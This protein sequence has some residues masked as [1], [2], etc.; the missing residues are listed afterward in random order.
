MKRILCIIE[1]LG[2][3]GA[4]RQIVGLSCLF[5]KRGYDVKQVYWI[6]RDDNFLADDLKKNNVQVELLENLRDKKK[7]FFALYNYIRN[8]KPQVV[9]SYTD[10][11]SMILCVMVMFGA[12]FRLVVSERSSTLNLTLKN[13][14]KF[15]LYRFAH[16]VVP[17]SYNEA[18]FIQ[19]NFKS[20][21]KKVVP[22]TN[23]T[24]TDLFKPIAQL[25]D[26]NRCIVVARLTEAKNIVNFLHA[27]RIVANKGYKF[28]V[29]WYGN[30][31]ERAYSDMVLGERIKLN[32]EDYID[33][34]PPKSDINNIYPQY[35]FSCLPSSYEGFPNVVCEAM[36]CGLPVVC[37]DVSD[38][39]QIIDAGI[40]GI[41]FNPNN[42]DEI[43]DKFMEMLKKSYEQRIQMG[44]YSRKLAVERFSKERFINQYIELT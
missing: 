18:R 17:N 11:S 34:L 23:F 15:F 14:V 13:R 6:K 4:Q 43:A 44:A 8:K 9:I 1:S 5:K 16:S 12:K 32:L 20:L 27:L 21:N 10:S 25:A 40:N 35:S 42:V 41:L 39:A 22:I 24:D 2:S 37:S 31:T 33:F 26:N 19:S 29:D 38:N 36:S 7:R 3:G 30:Q 28:K